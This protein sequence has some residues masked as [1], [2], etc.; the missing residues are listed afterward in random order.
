MCARPMCTAYVHS[1][2][3]RPMRSKCKHSCSHDT[4]MTY[5]A[6]VC[7]CV[8]VFLSIGMCRC[9]YDVGV[10]EGKL[11]NMIYIYVLNAEMYSVYTFSNLRSLFAYHI[12]SI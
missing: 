6:C 8:F 1:L 9:V 5:H 11:G 2:C 12:T 10:Y 4:H 7:R 3:A